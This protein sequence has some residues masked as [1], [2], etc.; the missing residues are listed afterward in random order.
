MKRHVL[1]GTAGRWVGMIGM[2]GAGAQAARVIAV[3]VAPGP[4]ELAREKAED[5]LSADEQSRTSEA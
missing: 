3:D 1:T 5:V 2:W 4:L